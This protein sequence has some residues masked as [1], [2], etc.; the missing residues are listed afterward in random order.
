VTREKESSSFSEEKEPKRL[1][2]RFAMGV[3]PSAS[4]QTNQSFLLL[5]VHKKKLFLAL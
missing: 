1:L 2:V 3:S 4:R 5:F